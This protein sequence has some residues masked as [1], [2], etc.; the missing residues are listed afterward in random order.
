L[1]CSEAK[2]NE[3]KTFNYLND[4]SCFG[5]SCTDDQIKD[6]FNTLYYPAL[7]LAYIQ[8]K[9]LTCTVAGTG[10]FNPETGGSINSTGGS[11]NSTGGSNNS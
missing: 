9:D 6:L 8:T 3:K 11:N 2:K 7:E 4:V 5:T 1:T 10:G